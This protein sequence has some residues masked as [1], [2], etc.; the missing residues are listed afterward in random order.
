[1]YEHGHGDLHCIPYAESP[2]D[3]RLTPGCHLQRPYTNTTLIF[4]W[5]KFCIL[6]NVERLASHTLHAD[7]SPL[8]ISLV[9]AF[10]HLSIWRQRPVTG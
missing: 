1:M 8:V 3:A 2:S 9:P 5:D 4:L 10:H 6:A 7:L